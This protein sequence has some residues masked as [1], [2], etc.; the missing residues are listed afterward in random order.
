MMI[1][2]F[3]LCLLHFDFQ[4]P[5]MIILVMMEYSLMELKMSSKWKLH[6]MV[7]QFVLL[8]FFYMLIWVLLVNLKA[9]SHV[10]EL[11]TQ[12]HVSPVVF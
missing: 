4:S 12:C 9:S 8:V 7:W 11:F 1:A 6:F 2:V 10:I 3:L 5:S